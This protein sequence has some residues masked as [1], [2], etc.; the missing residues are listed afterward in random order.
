M[1]YSSK[2]KEAPQTI[3]D[4]LHEWGFNEQQ[5]NQI[6]QSST[7]INQLNEHLNTQNIN[8]DY[9]KIKSIYEKDGQSFNTVNGFVYGENSFNSKNYGNIYIAEQGEYGATTKYEKLD[10]LIHELGHTHYLQEI[11]RTDLEQ[12]PNQ[13]MKEYTQNAMYAEGSAEYFKNKVF[14][15]FS[16]DFRN[17]ARFQISQNYDPTK[18]IKENIH[19]LSEEY[20]EKIA[21][22]PEQL[23]YKYQYQWEYLKK[24]ELLPE[25]S[26]SWTNQERVAFINSINEN[27][28]IK[29]QEVESNET[30]LPAEKFEQIDNNS[31]NLTNESPY[32]N[33]NN[34]FLKERLNQYA[35]DNGISHINTYDYRQFANDDNSSNRISYLNDYNISFGSGYWNMPTISAFEL[36]SMIDRGQWDEV[37]NVL[38][39]LHAGTLKLDG[40]ISY[41]AQ[42]KLIGSST[43]V[44]AGDDFFESRSVAYANPNEYYQSKYGYYDNSYN[45]S[46]EMNAINNSIHQYYEMQEYLAQQE[47]WDSVINDIQSSTN[48]M[49]NTLSGSLNNNSDGDIINANSS[50]DDNQ[51]IA[52][53][54]D[55]PIILVKDENEIDKSVKASEYAQ[56]KNLLQNSNNAF[57]TAQ[58]EISEELNYLQKELNQQLDEISVQEENSLMIDNEDLDN[59]DLS[60]PDDNNSNTVNSDLLINDDDIF[61][62][63]SDEEFFAFNDDERF[64]CKDEDADDYWF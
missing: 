38:S 53:V 48:N 54:S 32:L 36:E 39:D 11:A 8:G 46:W 9:A 44:F 24:K 42:Q 25:G 57:D 31:N 49:T 41:S 5:I 27:K 33:N 37:D 58:Q 23:Q 29:N 34:N 64:V 20:A 19:Q 1:I 17:E 30:E 28:G 43:S 15:E 61:Q 56:Y 12:N 3:N 45:L 18:S 7:L 50:T 52:K 6:Y 22:S 35:E 13:S 2:T 60:L 16:E 21:G 59:S 62:I 26:E 63:V 51:I 40:E 47:Y 14:S 4:L 55:D 10:T